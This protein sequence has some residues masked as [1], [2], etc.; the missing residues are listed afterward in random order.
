[1]N[2][3]RSIAFWLAGIL[4]GIGQIAVG[5]CLY[6]LYLVEGRLGVIEGNR[7]TSADQAEWM[8]RHNTVHSLQPRQ[9]DLDTRLEDHGERL[10]ELERRRG[11]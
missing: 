5:F 8:Q 6:E 10:R 4:F 9:G 3:N 1:M 7:W 11:K 2:G